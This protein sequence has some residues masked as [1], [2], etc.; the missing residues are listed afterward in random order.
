MREVC[1]I[2]CGMTKFGELW[3]KSFR[4]IFV[5]AALKAIDDGEVEKID[6]MYV[7]TMTS[8]LFVG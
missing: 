1:V 5:E 6:S 4:D 2:G 3:A 8:G 7:G